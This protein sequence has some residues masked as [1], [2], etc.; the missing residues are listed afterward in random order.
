MD[1]R[2]LSGVLWR[3]RFLVFSGFCVAAALTFLSVARVNPGG[4]PMFAYRGTETWLGT[5]RVFVTESGFPWGRRIITPPT[6]GAPSSTTESDPGR[7]SSLAILYSNLA[8]GD[9][10]R[11]ILLKGGPYKAKFSAAPLQADANGNTLPIIQISATGTSRQTANENA[12]RATLA[13]V[14]YI[15]QQQIAN[16]IPANQRVQLQVI[17][18]PK[19]PIIIAGRPKVIPFLVFVSVMGLVIGLALALENLRPRRQPTQIRAKSPTR[20]RRSA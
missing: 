6:Q 10:V 5:A 4:S 3:F 2:L 9:P 7:L 19:K 18:S 11:R 1:L 15:R 17:Q 20:L 12:A 14:Q 8:T 13:L 16:K